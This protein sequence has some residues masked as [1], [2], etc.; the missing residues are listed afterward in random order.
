MAVITE[1]RRKKR[2]TGVLKKTLV[3]LLQKKE[4][5]Q[6]SV[7]SLTDLADVSRGTFYLHYSDI[8][9][10]YNALENDVVE[11]ITAIITASTPA[12]DA[13]N[14]LPMID[15]IF[16]Y[17]RTH[18][19]VCEALLKTNSSSFLSHVFR[20]NRPSDPHAWRRLPGASD[21]AREY[22][23]NFVCYGFAG[24]LNNWMAG[25]KVEN[26]REVSE[27]VIQLISSLIKFD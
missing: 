2:T 4:L 22:F 14:L 16:E 20:S 13:G 23:Y 10:L 17:L 21:S 27:T 18:S 24:I 19:D 25:G 5:K 6:I 3:C 9:D 11:G 15:G 8:H 7:R 1:D 12:S 26:P